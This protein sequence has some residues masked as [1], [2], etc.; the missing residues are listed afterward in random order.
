MRPMEGCER[1]ETLNIPFSEEFT[2]GFSS[3]FCE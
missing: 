2:Q 1:E 3:C